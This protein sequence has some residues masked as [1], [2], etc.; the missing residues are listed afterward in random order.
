MNV[1]LR[2]FR[3]FAASAFAVATVVLLFPGVGP[4]ADD[5]KPASAL[6]LKVFIL[7][8]QSNIL[9]G[10]SN[11]E[12]VGKIKADP[13]RNDGRGS[14]EYLVKN[15]KTA[16]QFAHTIDRNGKWIIRDDAWIS[17]LDRRGKLTVGFGA[18][19][20]TI[21]PEF[22][23]G[24]VVGDALKNPVL[25]IKTAWGGKSLVKDFRPPTSGGKTGVYYDEM[26]KIIKNTLADLKTHAP[27][28]DGRAGYEI[29][30]LAWHQGWNDGLTKP[31]VAEYETNLANLI[32]DLRRD[33]GVKQLPVVIA[34]S[35]FG[36][37]KQKI[38]RRLGIINAQLAV[39]K[40]P[41]FKGTVKSVETR[42]Y[43][44]QPDESPGRQGYHWNLNA[45]T[46]FL[47]GDAMG[48]AMLDLL[49]L[50]GMETGKTRKNGK[51]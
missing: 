27:G 50:L 21:G 14:L 20:D 48:R 6:P 22:Q 17:Y 31:A 41:E 12:G 32:V 18:R 29:A 49:D 47:I 10:Q 11:M 33:L 45:E 23:F 43:F 36:G 44:R 8:G 42:G 26:V 19:K 28:Y 25:L 34:A 38:D 16:R 2:S 37:W 30:G 51:E 40:R 13:K 46:Y 35:G 24:H 39:A 15:S 5:K 1:R 4:A 9:A 3:D 7:A